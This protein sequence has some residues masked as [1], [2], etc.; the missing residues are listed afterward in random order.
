MLNAEGPQAERG[1]IPCE[2][3]AC[4]NKGRLDEIVKGTKI[5]A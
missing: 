4:E 1:H 2:P 3:W 5:E